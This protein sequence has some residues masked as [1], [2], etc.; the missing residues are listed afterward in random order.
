MVK[1]G[2]GAIVNIS[3]VHGL[4]AARGWAVYD[5]AKAGIN[6]LTRQIAVDYGPQGIRCNAICPGWI[7]VESHE[8]SLRKDPLGL[9]LAEMTYPLG[10]P[11]RPSD[12]ARAALFLASDEASFITGHALVVDGGMTIQLQDDLVN[13]VQERLKKASWFQKDTETQA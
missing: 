10:R 5:A 12:V 8:P 4:L 3:S 9:R 6:N 11:G 1:G 13:S 7:I 2:G